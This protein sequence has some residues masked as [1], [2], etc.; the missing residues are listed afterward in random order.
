MRDMERKAGYVG[1]VVLGLFVAFGL[2][3]A[4]NAEQ[5]S[6]FAWSVQAE[7]NI[8]FIEVDRRAAL[9]Y[10]VDSISQTGRIFYSGVGKDSSQFESQLGNVELNLSA[11]FRPF[12][13]FLTVEDSVFSDES[14]S[15]YSS[16]YSTTFS[17][18]PT[19]EANSKGEDVE[20]NRR[21]WAVGFSYSPLETLEIKFGYA[22]QESSFDDST[23]EFINNGASTFLVLHDSSYDFNESGPTIG[24]EY[25]L[26]L[27]VGAI[28]FSTDYQLSEQKFTIADV[29]S[30]GF[31][32]QS[33]ENTTKSDGSAVTFGINWVGNIGDS[34]TYIVGFSQ[35]ISRYKSK[36]EIESFESLEDIS[37]DEN[38]IKTD[39]DITSFTAGIGFR[40]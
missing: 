25:Q 15:S 34:W 30:N 29:A 22:E 10:T 24:V 20:S 16:F 8:K 37:L 21:S 11:G 32:S 27:G 40:F 33:G 28:H 4:A 19:S 6:G 18:G 2:V 26:D 14:E 23:V 39:I 7:S 36:I 12:S 1:R 9:G 38:S 13:V 31:E 17:P 35:H 3:S 5:D